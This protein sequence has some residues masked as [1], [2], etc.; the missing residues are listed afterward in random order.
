MKIV[1]FGSVAIDDVQ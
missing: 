1:L